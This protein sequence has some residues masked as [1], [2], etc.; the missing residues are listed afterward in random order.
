MAIFSSP[1]SVWLSAASIVRRE[2]SDTLDHS[3]GREVQQHALG[4]RRP[5]TIKAETNAATPID[6][7]TLRSSSYRMLPVIRR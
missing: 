5:A 7:L 4:R 2:M 3:V 1:I 6:L